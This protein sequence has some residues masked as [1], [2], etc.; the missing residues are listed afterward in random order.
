MKH[1]VRLISV[2]DVD[3]TGRFAPV[4]SDKF[5]KEVRWEGDQ[6]INDLPSFLDF[7]KS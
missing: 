6:E 5:G 4:E 2:V 7:W 1:P 3:S